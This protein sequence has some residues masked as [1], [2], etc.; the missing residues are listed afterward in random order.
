MIILLHFSLLAQI[1]VNILSK[2]RKLLRSCFSG[3]EERYFSYESTRALSDFY[4]LLP[5]EASV[6]SPN[7]YQYYNL[8]SNTMVLVWN[9]IIVHHSTLLLTWSFVLNLCISKDDHLLQTK[10]FL[11]IQ[12]FFYPLAELYESLVLIEVVFTVY[13]MFLIFWLKAHDVFIFMYIIYIKKKWYR[14]LM[15]IVHL[16]FIIIHGLSQRGEQQF[17]QLINLY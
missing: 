15:H 13:N 3:E 4:Y 8:G 17:H 2:E 6:S 7:P 10:I 12:I 1:L 14:I 11:A 16:Y 9:F 5:W